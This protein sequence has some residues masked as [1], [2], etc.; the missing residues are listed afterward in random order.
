MVPPNPEKTNQP[1][2]EENIFSEVDEELRR[3]R[4]RNLWRLFAPYVIGAAIAI[5]ALVAAYEGWNWWQNSNAARSSDAFYS[6]I[7]L[8]GSGDIAGAQAALETLAEDGSGQYPVLARFRQASLLAGD[9]KTDEAVAAYDALAAT[10]SNR[11]LRDLAL[12][13]AAFVLVDGGDVAPVE[14]RVG[15]LTTPDNPMRNSAREALGLAQYAAGDIDTARATFEAIAADP[16]GSLQTIGRIQIYIAQLIAE[17][18][19]APAGPA[20]E[21]PAN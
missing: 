2:S 20:A 1:M 14:A 17:G 12:V 15:G 18:A 11:R 9:G 8:A 3:E 13:L 10:I 6:A 19:K 21:T 7:D 4:M 16:S 5:V